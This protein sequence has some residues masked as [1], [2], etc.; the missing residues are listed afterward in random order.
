MQFTKGQRLRA[1]YHIESTPS[2]IHEL[3]RIYEKVFKSD[4]RGTHLDD[5]LSFNEDF[6]EMEE[7]VTWRRD[8]LVKLS[9]TSYDLLKKWMKI[10]D[11][12]MRDQI[13]VNTVFQR[14]KLTRLGQT[15]QTLTGSGINSQIIFSTSSG[16]WSAG[17][18]TQIFSHTRRRATGGEVTQTFFVVNP[19]APLS[20]KDS[21]KDC[22][23]TFPVAGGRLFYDMVCETGPILLSVD[24]VKSHFALCRFAIAEIEK[25]CIL[26]LPLDKVCHIPYRTETTLMSFPGVIW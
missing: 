15:F 2:S 18:I 20:P 22:Y 24:A 6:K 4:I 23:R 25:D 3:I 16:D 12:S 1:L 19:Y 26:A 9:D 17:S 21:K 7:K 8:E 13:L 5:V 10:N 14:S 11:T